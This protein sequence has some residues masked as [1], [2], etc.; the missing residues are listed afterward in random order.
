MK[1]AVVLGPLYDWDHMAFGIVEYAAL[2][3]AAD[4]H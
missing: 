3:R 2:F 4:N 1:T